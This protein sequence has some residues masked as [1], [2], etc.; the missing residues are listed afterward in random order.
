MLINFLPDASNFFGPL[1]QTFAIIA[2]IFASL[3]TIIQQDTKKLIAYSSIAQ[4][5]GPLNLI[6]LL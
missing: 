6:Y 2:I 4:S 5:N 3:S 1:V